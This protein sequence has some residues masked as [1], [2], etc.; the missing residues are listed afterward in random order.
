MNEISKSFNSKLIKLNKRQY[1]H[2]TPLVHTCITVNFVQKYTFPAHMQYVNF[3][4]RNQKS[5][6]IKIQYINKLFTYSLQ[7]KTCLN[8][9]LT[10]ILI[11]FIRKKH[12]IRQECLK[13][14]AKFF[15]V[16]SF[17]HQA[18]IFCLRFAILTTILFV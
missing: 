7:F 5:I 4:E 16:I 14:T 12:F 1:H 17:Q 2:G 11:I 8:L 18:F 13:R 9:I 6:C 10:T 15:E 3:M